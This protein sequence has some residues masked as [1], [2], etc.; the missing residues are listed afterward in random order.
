[1]G[2]VDPLEIT[3]GSVH[4]RPPRPD[5]ADAV[6]AACQ[7]PEIQRWT[8]VPV[9]YE[10]SDAVT[11]VARVAPEGWAT[12]TAATFLVLDSTTAT[13]LGCVGLH[14]IAAGEAQIGYWLV[15]D[16]RGRGVGTRAV[17]A[18]VRWG[19]GGLGLERITWTAAVGNAASWRLVERL[20]FQFEGTLRK[21]LHHRDRRVDGWI[22]ALLADDPVPG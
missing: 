1:M 11:F 4:L 16:A 7:D 8:R 13:L 6:L 20:G 18:V 21:G 14:R 17:G 10:R 5:D 15:A 12:G 3:A 22:G 2:Q 19:F 9:P